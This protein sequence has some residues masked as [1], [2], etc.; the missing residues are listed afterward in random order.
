MQSSNKTLSFHNLQLLAQTCLNIESSSGSVDRN[1]EGGPASDPDSNA[2]QTLPGT[3]GS[4]QRLP[5]LDEVGSSPTSRSVVSDTISPL[6]SV[7]QGERKLSFVKNETASVSDLGC[8]NSSVESRYP[9]RSLSPSVQTMVENAASD[10]S[11]ISMVR[12]DEARERF[13]EA[14]LALDPSNNDAQAQIDNL[15]ARSDKNMPILSRYF[16]NM[17]ELE[18]YVVKID[19]RNE[20]AI[21]ACCTHHDCL[22]YVRSELQGTLSLDQSRRLDESISRLETKLRK[23]YCFVSEKLMFAKFELDGNQES[24]K[25]GSLKNQAA[26]TESL[27]SSKHECEEIFELLEFLESQKGAVIPSEHYFHEKMLAKKSNIIHDNY[28]QAQLD[29]M[30]HS[31]EVFKQSVVLSVA[32]ANFY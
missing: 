8:S 16:H 26:A 3:I 30:I 10:H 20:A 32:E 31:V 18:K 17:S 22:R 5:G 14:F 9:Q 24:I 23:L 1:D 27:R 2:S 25:L 13:V 12:Y 19:A 21:D 11:N 28:D 15:L 6:F 7:F 29:E 4:Q